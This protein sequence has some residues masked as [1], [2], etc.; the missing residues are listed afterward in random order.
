MEVDELLTVS[1]WITRPSFCTLFPGRSL[2]YIQLFPAVRILLM[3]ATFEKRGTSDSDLIL[4]R[5]PGVHV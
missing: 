1:E 5:S 4:P 3:C 2:T